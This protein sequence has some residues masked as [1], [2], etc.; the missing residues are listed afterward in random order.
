MN[1]ECERAVAKFLGRDLRATESRQAEDAVKL[2]MRLAAAKDPQAWSALSAQERLQKGAEAAAQQIIDEVKLQQRR[3]S[4]QIAAHDRI[5][6][7]LA[8]RFAQIDQTQPGR[9]QR[10]MRA[11]G[12]NIGPGPAAKLRAVSQLLAFDPAGG[13]IQSADTW[14]HAIAN[15]AVGRLLPLWGSV[16]AWGLFEDQ[17]GVSDLVHEIY[18]E[19]T[20]NAVAKQAA[21]MWHQVTSELRD[22]ANAAGADIGK[23]DPH[24][25]G[26]PHSHS[27]ARIGSTPLEKWISDT[28]PLLAREKYLHVDGTRY[29]DAEMHSLLEGAYDSIVTDGAADPQFKRLTQAGTPTATYASNAGYGPLANRGSQHRQLFFKDADSWLQYQGAYG[30]RSLWPTLTGHIQTLARDIGM[31]ETLGPNPLQTFRFFNDRTLLE[32]RRA[33]PANKPKIDSW[34]AFNESLYDYAAGQR[35]VPNPRIAAIGQAWRNFETAAK[36]GNVVLTALGDE[37]GMA[38]TA[39]ANGIPWTE[40]MMRELTLA[41]AKGQRY[42]IQA[43]GVGINHVLGGLNRFGA[44]DFQMYG[45]ASQAE[46]VRNFTSKLAT[47]VLTA[48]GAEFMWDLRRQALGSLLMSYIGKWSREAAT[49]KD[50][51]FA[52]AG[53]LT[54]KGVTEADWQVWKRAQPEQ[55]DGL[56]HGAVTPR[57]IAAIP[58][59]QLRDLG[60]PA[61]LRRHASTALLGH[62]LEET[63]MGVMD[64]GIRERA[65][66]GF[67][68][69][70]G[71]LPGELARSAFLFK[72]FGWSMMMK[73]W[74]RAAE[75]PSAGGSW[76]YMAA[77]FTVGTIMGAV[78]TQL[79]NL[80]QGKDPSNIADPS[81]WGE[82]ILRGGGMGFYGDFLYSETTQHDTSLIPALLGPLATSAEEVWNL[83]GAA[84]LKAQRGERVDEQAK[85][86]RFAKG[87]IPFLNMWYTRAAMDHLLWNDMQEA[88]SPGYLDRMQERAQNERG[89]TWWWNPQDGVPRGPPNLA[90]AWQP[91]AGRE[92]IQRFAQ[93]ISGG[94]GE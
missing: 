22:R 87:N 15:E 42:E 5:E 33:F 79:R 72:S 54:R 18:G 85:L 40:S 74:A 53:M 81:Y 29:S 23:L 92:K 67:G 41:A 93:A 89:T 1:P 30:D 82:S 2:Q 35:R 8:D 91:E 51:N 52:D 31:I 32:E 16:K 77:L 47:G 60:D 44:E 86:I 59:E 68:T 75:M 27:Q 6:A 57:A 14:S 58:D 7:T 50:L 83:S 36:L 90:A 25:W 12:G 17:K 3:V 61:A 20:G 49:L 80:S 39:Y 38:A 24:E 21:A 94:A 45:G 28:L 84:L 66:M 13:R 11:V 88:V 56:E 9:M 46:A 10:F 64:T 55:W 4:L 69:Q 63:G 34:H 73:H 37:A 70:S 48:S 76:R 65:A 71:T 26:Y 62:V 43:N 19:D 78:A